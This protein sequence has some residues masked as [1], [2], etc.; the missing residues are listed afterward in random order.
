MKSRTLII[1]GGS[2][3][4]LIILRSF[5]GG[6]KEVETEIPLRTAKIVQTEIVGKST[7]TEQIHVTGR[8][9]PIRETIVSTQ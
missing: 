7:F 2:L 6:N 4:L 5:F 9:A 8:V 3:L 1:I